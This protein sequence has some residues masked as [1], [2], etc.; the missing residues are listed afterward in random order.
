MPKEIVTNCEYRC[1]EPW[2]EVGWSRN[3]YVQVGVRTEDENK[4]P[5][6]VRFTDLDRDGINKLIRILRKARDQAYGSD[7]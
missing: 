4:H 2:L 1:G 3:T 5:D 7:A 6:A